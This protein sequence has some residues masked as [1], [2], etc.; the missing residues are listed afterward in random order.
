[1][2]DHAAGGV[3]A[4]LVLEDAMG[5]VLLTGWLGVGDGPVGSVLQGPLPG[6]QKCR[7]GSV[8]VFELKGVDPDGSDVPHAQWP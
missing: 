2:S 1:M 7:K 6:G 8:V 4:D 5:I 3:V